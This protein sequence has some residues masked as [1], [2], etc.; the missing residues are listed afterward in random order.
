MNEQLSML[1]QIMDGEDY[2]DLLRH[3]EA[4]KDYANKKRKWERAFQKWSNEQLQDGTTDKGACGYGVMC[5]WCDDPSRGNPC[6][7][8]L[9]A[10]CRTKHKQIDYSNF[11]FAEVW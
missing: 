11:D 7:R 4:M 5:D 1:P 2:A 8:A 3:V 6:V 9:N 10:M